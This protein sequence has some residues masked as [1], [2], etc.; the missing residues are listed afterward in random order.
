MA[1][2]PPKPP[3]PTFAVGSSS[4]KPPP[5]TFTG[6]PS[7]EELI[8]SYLRHRIV[9]GTK[10]SDFIH[11]ADLYAA[12]PDLLTSQYSPATADDGERTWYFFTTLRPRAPSKKHKKR[13]VDTG[14]EGSWANNGPKTTVF[15]YRGGRRQW[16]GQH[17][18]FAFMEKVD[19]KRVRS[20]WRMVELSLDSDEGGQEAGSSN[21]LVLCKVYRNP[22]A[23][24]DDESSMA[25]AVA[26]ADG[27]GPAASA[28][29][30][31][32][33]EDADEEIGAETAAGPGRK[34]KAGDKDSGAETVAASPGRQKKADGDGESTYAATTGEIFADSKDP[35]DAAEK[36]EQEE[37][38]TSDIQ[39]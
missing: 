27:E 26:E 5:A 14:R 16:I 24:V 10:V 3:P 11:E 13:K 38:G 34:R 36:A 8:D 35:L 33:R 2:S 30:T 15:S 21:L 18:T 12:D 9:S 4:P 20:A 6:H 25:V 19:G 23:S 29:V 22:N 1:G 28:V 31:P 17:Q 37:T 39:F 7:Y 32:G